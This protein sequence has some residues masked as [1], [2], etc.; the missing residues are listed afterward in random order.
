MHKIIHH[1]NC[2]INMQN[3]YLISAAVVYY[4]CY[5]YLYHSATDFSILIG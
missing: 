4:R 3:Q 5:L 2:Y 1:A